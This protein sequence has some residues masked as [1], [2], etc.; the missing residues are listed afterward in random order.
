MTSSKPWFQRWYVWTIIGVVVA[1]AVTTVAVVE[2]RP[3]YDVH[4]DTP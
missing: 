4:I 1:G 2:T 3:H